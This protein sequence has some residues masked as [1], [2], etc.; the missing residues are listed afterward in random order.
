MLLPAAAA[1]IGALVMGATKPR[2]RY[3]K[4]SAMGPR[5]GIT[6]EVEDFPAAGFIVVRAPDG[7]EG[8][9]SRRLPSD[10]TGFEWS[11]GRGNPGTLK[12]MR[13]DF[14]VPASR[15]GASSSGGSPPGKV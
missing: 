15:P 9:F 2:T 3:E 6:Y 11:R 12:L 4:K 8:V 13:N 10:G 1:V 14:G 5:S 7:T